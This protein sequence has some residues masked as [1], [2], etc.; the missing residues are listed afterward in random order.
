MQPIFDLPFAKHI[1]YLQGYGCDHISYF[2]VRDLVWRQF[3]DDTIR[4]RLN[5]PLTE[6]QIADLIMQN[7]QRALKKR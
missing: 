1:V 4:W 7:E 2:S 6:E 5:T 3:Q